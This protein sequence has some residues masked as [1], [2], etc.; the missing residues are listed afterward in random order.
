MIGNK[1]FKLNYTAKQ[2]E[3]DPRQGEPTNKRISEHP[4]R[5]THRAYF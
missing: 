3:L 2:N 4:I 1:T 5:A